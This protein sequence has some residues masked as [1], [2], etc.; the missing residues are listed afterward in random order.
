MTA[1][2]DSPTIGPDHDGYASP[3]DEL[4]AAPDPGGTVVRDLLGHLQ[5]GILTA[6]SWR[7]LEDALSEADIAFNLG[8]LD[9]NQVENLASQAVEVSRGI[10]EQ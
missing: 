10:P 1:V 4:A 9:A 5:A 8:E 3:Q 2:F 6:N 7:Q